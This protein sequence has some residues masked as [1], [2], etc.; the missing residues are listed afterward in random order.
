M[1][2]PPATLKP[3]AHPID[4]DQGITVLEGLAHTVSH[5]SFA[6]QVSARWEKDH[7]IIYA[8]AFSTFPAH[9]ET[10]SAITSV[11]PNSPFLPLK[12]HLCSRPKSRALT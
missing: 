4:Y 11:L 5:A 7:H 12:T 3:L 9:T 6:L 1:L 10:R 8:G 2:W